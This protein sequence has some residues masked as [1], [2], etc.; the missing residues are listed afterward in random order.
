MSC[1]EPIFLLL[2]NRTLFVQIRVVYKLIGNRS[3]L[4]I[5]LLSSYWLSYPEWYLKH[6]N[7][8]YLPLPIYTRQQLTEEGLKLAE[9]VCR[10]GTVNRMAGAVAVV[11]TAEAAE[12]EQRTILQEYSRSNH[13]L[14]CLACWTAW[15]WLQLKT[16]REYRE[17]E[18]VKDIPPQ[19]MDRLE[20]CPS[21]KW[22][23]LI[24]LT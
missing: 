22:H 20:V 16:L 19:Y 1:P 5:Y 17:R 15:I 2:M 12:D 18:I 10:M 11:A 3:L 13:Y 24:L 21:D 7:W 8:F 14:A 9:I 6:T 23:R 4:F